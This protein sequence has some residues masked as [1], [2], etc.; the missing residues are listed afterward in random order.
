MYIFALRISGEGQKTA[1]QPGLILPKLAK[2]Y[3]DFTLGLEKQ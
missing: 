1:K 3:E 2:V